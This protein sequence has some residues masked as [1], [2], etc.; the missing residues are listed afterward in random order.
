MRSSSLQ[1]PKERHN[2]RG[3]SRAASVESR[4]T[5]RVVGKLEAEKNRL[6]DARGAEIAAL[7]RRVGRC[8]L[9]LARFVDRGKDEGKIV[10]TGA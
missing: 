2:R 1:P 10:A 3:R 9:L 5:D 4:D 6:G 8:V 7:H